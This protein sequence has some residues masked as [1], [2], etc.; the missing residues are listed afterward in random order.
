M[1]R[2]VSFD[3]RSSIGKSWKVSGWDDLD[4]PTHVL[5]APDN[6][7]T[8]PQ[9]VCGALLARYSAAISAGE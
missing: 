7:L 1:R 8:R 6:V 2:D 3:Q 5:N 4:H 9:M